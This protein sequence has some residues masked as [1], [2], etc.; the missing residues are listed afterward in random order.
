MIFNIVL[1][2]SLLG[3]LMICTHNL[4]IL[5]KTKETSIYCKKMFGYGG[6][7]LSTII[8]IVLTEVSVSSEN[9][10]QQSASFTHAFKGL[11]LMCP[12]MPIADQHFHVHSSPTSYSQTIKIFINN[13]RNIRSP[14]ISTKATNNKITS[15]TTKQGEHSKITAYFPRYNFVV[16]I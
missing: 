1:L 4:I 8:S 7:M 9:G 10:S 6:K 5:T 14:N 16:A 11:A 3:S 12:L 2:Q 13:K 15:S